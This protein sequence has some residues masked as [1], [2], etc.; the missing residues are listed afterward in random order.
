LFVAKGGKNKQGVIVH[1]TAAQRKETDR[2]FAPGG[3]LF[4]LEAALNAK[5][6]DD[7]PLFPGKR[8]PDDGVAAADTRVSWTSTGLR[9]AMLDLQRAAGVAQKRGRGAYGF[10]RWAA[11]RAE[12]FSNDERALNAITSHAHTSTRR[13]Y[14]DPESATAHIA[15][16][17]V[18]D[19][20]RSNPVKK[21]AKKR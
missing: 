7:Y 10:R 17:E 11:D 20:L 12:D 14:Q 4:A 15:A 1:L 8:L 3:M 21:P 6:I 19:N 16:A 5:L 18:R 2:A 9:G 13:G